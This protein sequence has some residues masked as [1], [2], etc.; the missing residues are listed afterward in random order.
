MGLVAS[1]NLVRT[2]SVTGVPWPEA[3][4]LDGV[5]V[6]PWGLRSYHVCAHRHRSC[7]DIVLSYLPF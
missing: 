5:A 1:R 4:L 3:W 6:M 2:S 7:C